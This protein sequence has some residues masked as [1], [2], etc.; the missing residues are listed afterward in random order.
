MTLHDA[1]DRAIHVI[2]N[3]G[4]TL[5]QVLHTPPC[6]YCFEE[7]RPGR[8]LATKHFVCYTCAQAKYEDREYEECSDGE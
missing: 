8:M 4:A 3:P 2:L 5:Q 1:T 6:F 7:N